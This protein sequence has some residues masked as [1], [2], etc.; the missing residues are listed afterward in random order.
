MRITTNQLRRIIREEAGRA[1]REVEGD[2]SP[3]ESAVMNLKQVGTNASAIAAQLGRQLQGMKADKAAPA[4]T[5]AKIA[6]AYA[7]QIDTLIKQLTAVKEALN[8]AAQKK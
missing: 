5:E 6:S 4:G 1:M 8:S 3:A 7:P 2:D